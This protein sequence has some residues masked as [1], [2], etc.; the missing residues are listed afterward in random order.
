[1]LRITLEFEREVLLK[2]L[3]Q[4]THSVT[5]ISEFRGATAPSQA[6]AAPR[7]GGGETKAL[8]ALL[9]TTRE[10]AKALKISERTLWT[11]TT[12][13]EIPCVR[14]GR[15]VRYSP[16]DLERWIENSVKKD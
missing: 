13:R 12:Q 11:F 16:K 6:R 1:M 15:S 10:A 5:A 9:L 14:I 8:G 7:P 3:A 2:I 4:I